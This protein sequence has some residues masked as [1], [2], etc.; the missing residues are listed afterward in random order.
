MAE[1][2]K[3]PS[4]RQDKG[5]DGAARPES[6]P[7][8]LELGETVKTW[9]DPV[10]GKWLCCTA[11]KDVFDREKAPY[12]ADV[13]TIAESVDGSI[14]HVKSAKT[15]EELLLGHRDDIIKR[16]ARYE[17]R[18][19]SRQFFEETG[20][21]VSYLC[22]SHPRVV[23]DPPL[24]SD[25]GD[26]WAKWIEDLKKQLRAS[27][28]TDLKELHKTQKE[29]PNGPGQRGGA[30]AD[31]TPVEQIQLENGAYKILRMLGNSPTRLHQEDLALC[32]DPPMDRK[33]VSRHL[34]TLA[35]AGL[36]DYDPRGK[37]GAAILPKGKDYLNSLPK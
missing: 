11:L 22:A 29:P 8:P 3:D 28:A 1:H 17:D 37:K 10:T 21:H 16:F 12:N 13:E 27:A 35:E 6:T 2:N 34:T 33:T 26:R 15:L 36:I 23:E 19:E 9:W 31:G 14:E 5:Q 20:S 32:E 4:D 24:K 7:E 30:A 18:P 25:P